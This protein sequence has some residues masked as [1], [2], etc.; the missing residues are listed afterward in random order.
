MQAASPHQARRY[1]EDV[2]EANCTNDCDDFIFVVAPHSS[3]TWPLPGALLHRLPGGPAPSAVPTTHYPF[4]QHWQEHGGQS[5]VWSLGVEHHSANG[6]RGPRGCWTDSAADTPPP[7][8]EL[9]PTSPLAMS[10]RAFSRG[11]CPPNAIPVFFLLAP[12]EPGHLVLQ[13][14]SGSHTRVIHRSEVE[15]Q[16]RCPDQQ[17]AVPGSG[18]ETRAHNQ[19]K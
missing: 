11:A 8:S 6:D 5:A 7:L 3:A 2:G 9:L 1:V 16:Q 12:Y 14:R 10:W 18:P 4:H 17:Q 19:S 15:P 13:C